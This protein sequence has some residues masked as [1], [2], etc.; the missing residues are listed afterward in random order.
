MRED[1][2]PALDHTVVFSVQHGCKGRIGPVG[3]IGSTTLLPLT[4]ETTIDAV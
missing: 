3:I 2:V 1:P 4:L